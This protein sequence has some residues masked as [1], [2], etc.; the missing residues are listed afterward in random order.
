MASSGCSGT[1]SFRTTKTS[2]GAPECVG[3]LDGDGNAAAWQR[4]HHHVG[5]AGVMGEALGQHAPGF[6]S[7]T[8][9]LGRMGVRRF[10]Q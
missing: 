7:V 1:P 5:V 10:R 4:E 2:S 8:K 3:D 9:W 6:S